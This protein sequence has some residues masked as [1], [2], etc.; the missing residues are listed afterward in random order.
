MRTNDEGESKPADVIFGKTKARAIRGPTNADPR[1]YWRAERWVNAKRQTV[2]VGRATVAELEVEIAKALTGSADEPVD[3]DDVRTV[4]DLLDT[5][6][7]SVR[8]RADI[9]GQT[10]I[11]H[12]A[13]A[14][15]ITE[16]GFPVLDVRLERLDRLALERYR[17][18]RI[19]AGYAPQT[20]RQEIAAIGQ[21]W[22]WAR[23]LGAVPD[24]DPPRCTVRIPKVERRVAGAG[25]VGSVLRWLDQHAPP[26]VA[27]ATRLTLATGGRRGEIARLTWAD[28]V[29]ARDE[30]GAVK[31]ATVL[32]SG[33]T[34][35]R[36]IPLT[37]EIAELVLSWRAANDR[38]EDPM[39]GVAEG[40]VRCSVNQWL[41]RACDRLGIPRFS[42]HAIRRGA[43]SAAWRANRDPG[44]IVALFGH[45]AVT[46]VAMYDRPTEEDLAAAVNRTQLGQVPERGEVREFRRR[47][48]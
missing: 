41:H 10:R 26:W 33:K 7:A 24:R 1:W 44:V 36:R 47:D 23:D 13:T 2:W 42:P 19:R 31:T 35:P 25:E 18:G 40:T 14:K 45:D 8:E 32:L 12:E 20:V 30:R 34:G 29:I 43:V 27:R 3:P 28:L 39:F 11:T 16:S 48:E 21:A 9:R 37:R 46:S 5:W 15:R 4:Y 22:R 38:D 17:D 6:A